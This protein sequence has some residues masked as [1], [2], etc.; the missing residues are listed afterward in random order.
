MNKLKEK[1]KNM[2]KNQKPTMAI[3]FVVA[4][5]VIGV[6]YAY[7]TATAGGCRYN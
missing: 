6:S 1:F 3:V 5:S 4:L 7:F 2:T